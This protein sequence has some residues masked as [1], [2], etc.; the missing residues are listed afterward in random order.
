MRYRYPNIDPLQIC[1]GQLVDVQVRFETRAIKS[2]RPEFALRICSICILD[3]SIQ[4]VRLVVIF[5]LQIIEL[6]IIGCTSTEYQKSSSHSV[7]DPPV[8]EARG[9]LS[10]NDYCRS[11]KESENQ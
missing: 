2:K 10:A 3:R 1:A 11:P 7:F 5:G 9:W 6:H 4:M 8:F